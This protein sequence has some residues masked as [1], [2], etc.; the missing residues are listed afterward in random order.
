M[1][2]RPLS[3][4]E[5]DKDRELIRGI[6]RILANAGYTIVEARG[7]TLTSSSTSNGDVGL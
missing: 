3:E 1:D 4:K 2:F 5:K 6:P 7:L